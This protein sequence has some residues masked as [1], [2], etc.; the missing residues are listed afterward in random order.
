MRRG[1]REVS[2]I[3]DLNT[4]KVELTSPEMGK[5]VGREGKDQKSR[6]R[7][8]HGEFKVHIRYPSRQLNR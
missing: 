6:V 1:E 3:F 7:L 5:T 2:K 4:C 8:G